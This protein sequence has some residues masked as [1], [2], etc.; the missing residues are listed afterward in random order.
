[1]PFWEALGLNLPAD[2]QREAPRLDEFLATSNLKLAVLVRDAATNGATTPADATD[3]EDLLLRQLAGETS[4]KRRVIRWLRIL[5]AAVSRMNR[6]GA[7]IHPTRLAVDIEPP[8]SPFQSEHTGLAARAAAWESALFDWIGLSLGKKSNGLS[9]QPSSQHAAAIALSAA[10]CGGLLEARKLLALIH[11]VQDPIP[12]AGKLAYFDFESIHAGVKV[13]VLRRWLPD[14]VTEGLIAQ[15]D[16]AAASSHMTETAL[17]KA[18]R[19]IIGAERDPPR[20]LAALA[21]AAAA[22]WSLRASRVDVSVARG[23]VLTQSLKLAVWLRQN[24]SLP[25]SDPGVD[26]ST[27]ARREA[28][29]PDDGVGAVEDGSAEAE[30]K[31]SIPWLEDFLG[32]ADMDGSEASA[33]GQRQRMAMAV[34]QWTFDKADRWAEPYRTWLHA[35]LTG[36]NASG[37]RMAPSTI[38]QYFRSVVPALIGMIG[39]ENPAELPP[40]ELDGWYGDLVEPIPPGKSRITM[41]NGLREFHAHLQ[42]VH[43]VAPI[44]VGD[45][46][47]REAELSSVD[48]RIVNPDE[49]AAA[50]EWLEAQVGQGQF[51]A[52]MQAVSL[53]LL[54]AFRCGLRR[55]EVLMLRLCDLHPAARGDL[56]VVPHAAR[57]L[58]SKSSERNL[59]LRTLLADG[60]WDE[61]YSW[62]QQRCREATSP[63]GKLNAEQYLFAIPRLGMVKLPPESVVDKLHQALRAVTGDQ[64]IHLHHLR[65]S[66]ATW[67]YLRLRI[68]LYPP[69]A[70]HFLE[71]PKTYAWL[72]SGA[73]FSRKLLPGGSPGARSAAYA[74]ARL[75]GHS[76]ANISFEH[77][78]HCSDLLWAGLAC[79]QAKGLPR[80]LLIAATGISRMTGY[81][82]L[83]RS[84]EAL[85]AAV[86]EKWKAR[87][88]FHELDS[89]AGDRLPKNNEAG[90]PAA[91][92]EQRLQMISAILHRHDCGEP[93]TQ[94]ASHVALD[95][96]EV[97]W[98][99]D[100]AKSLTGRIQWQPRDGRERIRLCPPAWKG[101]ETRRFGAG[102]RDALIRLRDVNPQ[103]A[104][105]GLRTALA[106]FNPQRKD[107]VFQ[108]FDE[109]RE[110]VR[111]LE[112]LD[113]LG[114]ATCKPVVVVR[115]TTLNGLAAATDES[116]CPYLKWKRLLNLPD[117][118]PV[119]TSS[120]NS[121]KTA[122][123]RWLG[124]HLVPPDSKPLHLTMIGVCM[125]MLID[126]ELSAR[127]LTTALPS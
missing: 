51:P 40:G 104:I 73:D 97:E 43:K 84:I 76:G 5:Y 70:E 65:H 81:R 34:S 32:Q 29:A 7:S 122:Y 100:R 74:T 38:R 9:D 113:A 30:L 18:I 67:T 102:L 31:L 39:T 75:L 87:Y 86:R 64:F 91:S 85:M 42:K 124:F 33:E 47:G 114:P 4:S 93:A 117:A 88:M 80:P 44:N 50:R 41:A 36:P 57:R 12:V 45:V 71:W 35:M 90:S 83:D 2:L 49:V 56:R 119:C 13:E 19:R 21:T 59:P 8:K 94:I 108:S 72:A 68:G 120:P 62:W 25:R 14:P 26:R 92:S 52:L 89:P 22:L 37:D 69:L 126:I 106:R 11:R 1:M 60:E 123:R 54:L 15:L 101:V 105:S 109:A 46:L 127:N 115:D 20:S 10:L 111:F 95:P 53:V 116:Q 28:R 6:L 78:I 48:A 55:M 61:L 82:K 98:V 121:K 79:R 23:A 99:I 112:F 107:I 24:R 77:Y 63:D 3:L 118:D 103:L 96:D 125:L 110:A 66:F 17:V 27:R 58:K 16:P